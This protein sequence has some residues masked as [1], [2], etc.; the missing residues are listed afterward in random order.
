MGTRF[1]HHDRQLCS[2][3]PPPDFARGFAICTRGVPLQGNYTAPTAPLSARDA[4]DNHPAVKQNVPAVAAK[5][6]KEEECSFHL[7][8]PR[9]MLFFLNGIL[10]NPLQWVIM[11]GKG[12]ICVDCTD[13]PDGPDSLSSANTWI[14][15]PH[16]SVADECPPAYYQTAFMR[17]ITW[18]WRLRGTLPAE[19][20]LQHCDD[21]DAAF[22]C[23]LYHPNVAAA[24]AY[25]FTRYLV[26][27][28]GQVFGSRSAP[29]FL[30][31]L[32]DLRA[33]VATCGNLATTYPL[34]PQ[35]STLEH[36]P[37]IP[38]STLAAAPLDALNP[39]MTESELAN[40]CNITFV[41][42]NG[43]LAVARLMPL[44]V[45]NSIIAAFLLFG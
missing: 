2:D 9:L 8:F 15:K 16:P 40:F 17:Y 44:A 23:V 28:V 45:H 29:S 13:G 21:L 1:R 18:L 22:R 42:N 5:F 43:V 25:I 27:P 34:H 35:A 7:H 31:L 26:I 4:Y 30:S 6:A 3:L 36:P 12:R 37:P 19:P 33:Y 41:D 14:P 38:P 39:P 20:I 10:I 24:F 11:K 32:S